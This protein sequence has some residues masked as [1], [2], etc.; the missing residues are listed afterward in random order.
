[1]LAVSTFSPFYLLANPIAWPK[2][3]QFDLKKSSFNFSYPIKITEF[4][5][6]YESRFTSNEVR[7]A[8][9]TKNIYRVKQTAKESNFQCCACIRYVWPTTSKRSR[10]KRSSFVCIKTRNFRWCFN[11]EKKT[12]LIKTFI[13]LYHRQWVYEY[14]LSCWLHIFSSLWCIF[15]PKSIMTFH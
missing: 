8:W 12:F 4:R 15:R 2:L 3:E 14:L 10:R 5:S 7:V 1:M 11:L 6:K 9:L 13:L